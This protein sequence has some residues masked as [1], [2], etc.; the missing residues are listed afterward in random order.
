VAPEDH[1]SFRRRITRDYDDADPQ[2]LPFAPGPKPG[3]LRSLLDVV[4]IFSEGGVHG[5][6]LAFEQR[7]GPASRFPNPTALNGAAGWTFLNDPDDVRHVCVNNVNNYTDR[8]LPDVYSFVAGGRGILGSQ[9]RFN[10][11]HR[12][13]CAPPFRSP[14]LL[15]RFAADVVDRADAL[16][17]AWAAGARASG[18]GRLATD[19][20]EDVQRMTL[21]TIGRVAFSHDFGQVARVRD[22]VEGKGVT[23]SLSSSSFRVSS[24]SSAS[25][26]IVW[27]VN[28][29]GDM[30]GRIFITPMPMLKLMERF[31]DPHVRLLGESVDVM[32]TAMLD[33]IADRRRELAALGVRTAQER[34]EAGEDA[35][36][37]D[38]A[39]AAASS[40]LAA[41]SPSPPPFEPRDL[42]DS[43]LLAT[44]GDGRPL[45][46]DELWEDVHD[47]MGAGHE[48]TATTTA[49][50]LWSVA[51]NPDVE[52]RVLDELDAVLPDGRAPV[53]ADFERLVY[54]QAVVKETLRLYP[55]IPLFPRVAAEADALPSGFRVAAGEVCFMSSFAL[56]RSPRLWDAP[57]AFR[58]SR[59]MEDEGGGDI[60][61]FAWVP[62]GAG[63]RMCM[64]SGFALLAVTLT[65][66]RVLQLSRLVPVTPPASK[67]S[68]DLAYDIT[69]NFSKSGGLRMEVEERARASARTNGGV[70]AAREAVVS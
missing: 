46:D 49:A 23:S 55:A 34:W 19:V 54:T 40:S 30:L 1:D 2:D 53:H 28:T 12:Q 65:T 66:A 59:F 16:A 35:R 57:E 14:A 29:F 6:M 50:A 21:D 7:Y 67:G 69:M 36:P 13:L 22:R 5:A 24:S 37:V 56:G 31:G 11:R 8:Y 10:R 47:V 32:R 39:D 58:P 27:A 70:G 41:G 63:P 18:D 43:L 51:A 38:T 44:D 45:T 25:R 3:T 62:F 4:P 26:D 20:G 68:L 61:P 52:R 48:T 17:D 15:E 60:I 64:G 33:V 9:G 42:L